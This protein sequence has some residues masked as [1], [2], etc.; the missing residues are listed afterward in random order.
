MQVRQWITIPAKIALLTIALFAIFMVSSMVTG[1]TRLSAPGATT[2]A[3]PATGESTRDLQSASNTE[4]DNTRATATESD[5]RNATPTVPAGQAKAALGF[6]AACFLQSS[7]LAYVIMYSRW[8]GLRLGFTIFAILFGL[9]AIMTHLEMVVFMPR[10]LTEGA[11]PRLIGMNF[12]TAA[13]FAPLAVLVLG[14]FRSSPTQPRPAPNPAIRT[15]DLIT[16]LLAAIAVYLVLYFTFGYFIIWQDPTARAFYGGDPNADVASAASLTGLVQMFT[17][18]PKL[19][20]LQSARALM[21]VAL[22]WPVVRMMTG[23][24]AS[25]ALAVALLFGVLF[26]SQLLVPNPWMPDHVRWLHLLETSTSTFLFGLFVGW[27]LHRL[28]A[29]VDRSYLRK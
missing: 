12:V 10:A 20:L 7:V 21:W 3:P 16:C 11:L 29:P 9:T 2:E 26:P 19:V 5:T 4:S 25:A 14:K 28:S 13:L 18:Q 15:K 24:A 27:Q 6:L 17:G 1:M 23:G 8:H 22:A